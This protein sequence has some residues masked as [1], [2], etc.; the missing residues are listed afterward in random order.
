[1]RSACVA[2]VPFLFLVG[3]Q[4]CDARTWTDDSGVFTV[5]ADL[6]EIVGER[7]RLR[8]TDGNVITVPIAK[9]SDADRQYLRTLEHDDG[10]GAAGAQATG[11]RAVRRALT[12]PTTLDFIDTPLE[13]V[14]DYLADLHGIDVVVDRPAMRKDG[15]KAEMP[16]TASISERPLAEALDQ[17]LAQAGLAWLIHHDV[18]WI[19][20]P[21]IAEDILE[22]QFYRLRKPAALDDVVR[23][24][25][26]NIAPSGWSDVGG[27]ASIGPVPLTGTYHGLLIAAPFQ[28]HRQIER[29]YTELIE[30]VTGKPV[31]LPKTVASTTVAEGLAA[32]ITL[33]FVE[34]PLADAVE[35]L[36]KVGGVPITIDPRSDTGDTRVTIHASGVPLE[37]ALSLMLHETPF[38]WK[39]VNDRVVVGR[40]E[41]V[42]DNLVLGAYE[43][44]P[45]KYQGKLTHVAVALQ[46]TVEQAGWD[47]VG[48]PGSLREGVRGTLDVRQTYAVHRTIAALL[49]DMLEAA[50]RR[51]AGAGAPF[52]QNPRPPFPPG[53]GGGQGVF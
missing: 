49:G 16:V 15:M 20:T 36:G 44:D 4:P 11:A 10:D 40:P 6:V 23:D 50:Q 3:P 47:R 39:V 42:P 8:R 38:T 17:L 26:Q 52:R 53:F 19:T 45:L 21:T 24:I 41:A 14:A 29:H 46:H 30:P 43:V 13:D 34:T 1:M 22:T 35:Y 9:L 12:Q 32:P 48:G 5:E 33:E 7:V 18:L 25:T 51:A 37:S 27:M 2:L 31:K 28:V